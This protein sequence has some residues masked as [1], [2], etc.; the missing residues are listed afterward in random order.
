MELDG[1]RMVRVFEE[2]G[3][4]MDSVKVLSSRT[5]PGHQHSGYLRRAFVGLAVL[6]VGMDLYLERQ[7]R[8]CI[9]RWKE[10][11]AEGALAWV[12]DDKG[13]SRE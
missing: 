4:D 9:G 11:I 7:L 2:V 8:M 10:E 12:T 3:A 6:V 13:L 1:A 5:G